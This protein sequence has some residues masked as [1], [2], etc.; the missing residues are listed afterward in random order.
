[1]AASHRVNS[2]LMS[3]TEAAMMTHDPGMQAVVA[4]RPK[5]MSADGMNARPRP[6]TAISA[7]PRGSNTLPETVLVTLRASTATVRVSVRG[8]GCRSR[9]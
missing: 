6:K 9:R 5:V 8:T 7:A 3:R 2:P 1:M 4:M